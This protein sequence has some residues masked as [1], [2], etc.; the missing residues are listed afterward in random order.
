MI[1]KNVIIILRRMIR[2]NG[3]KEVELAYY[4]TIKILGF[5][6]RP[7]FYLKHDVSETTFCLR[8]QVLLTQLGHFSGD[9]D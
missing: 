3:V 2:R 9:R 6:H 7:G 1:K 8:L 5:I 4:I